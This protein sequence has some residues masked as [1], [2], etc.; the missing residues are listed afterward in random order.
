[1]KLDETR[2][3]SRGR[4]FLLKALVSLSLLAF[5]FWRTDIDGFINTIKGAKL[6]LLLFCLLLYVLSQ[7]I[8]TLRWQCLLN[9]EEFHVPFTRLV[10]FYFEGMFFNLFLPTLIGGDVVRGYNLYR[11]TRKGGESL[12]S[13]L[14]DRLSG[15][16]AMMAIA[17][18]ALLIGYPYL[19]EP[20]V[21][22]LILIIA[23]GMGL[24]I[25][26]LANRWLKDT[27]LSFVGKTGLNNFRERIGRTYEAIHR[28][29]EHRKAIGQ[30]LTLSLVLQTLGIFIFYLISRALGLSVALPYFFLFVPLI[31]VFSMIPISLS[32]LGVREG[33]TVFLFA[34]AGV[35]SSGALGLSLAWFSIVA[36][37]SLPGGM[38][39]LTERSRPG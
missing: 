37:A 29:R 21:A 20:L 10:L 30:A 34:K 27:L 32:G 31:H 16:M 22:Y 2:G 3:K 15:L 8:S 12:A 4:I 38:V 13:I 28:Y 35:S 25:F 33:I 17:L 24:G 9:A 39:F 7:L 5:L 11:Y 36:L 18:L 23:G 14:V 19:H 1:M 26:G 6:P